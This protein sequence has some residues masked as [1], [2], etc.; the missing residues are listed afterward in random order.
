MSSTTTNFNHKPIYLLQNCKERRDT[1]D[2]LLTVPSLS[3]FLGVERP[4]ATRERRHM[5]PQCS[6]MIR[7]CIYTWPYTGDQ[8][9]A[10]FL[11]I[12]QPHL[13]LLVLIIRRGQEVKGH[14]ESW[15]IEHAQSNGDLSQSEARTQLICCG[16][17]MAHIPFSALGIGDWLRGEYWI[18]VFRI[19]GFNI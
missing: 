10:H 4:M 15:E 11:P 14:I 5:T 18:S 17:F 16:C 12:N 1:R 13:R 3:T 6:G 2:K 9:T 8:A 19:Q 7:R